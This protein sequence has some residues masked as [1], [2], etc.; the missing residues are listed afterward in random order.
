MRI[1]A[2]LLW[3]PLAARADRRRQVHVDAVHGSDANSGRSPAEALA[4]TGAAQRAVR[5]L[6]AS[7]PGGAGVDVLLQ[8]GV[9]EHAA[10]LELDERDG[11]LS[12]ACPAAMPCW[13]LVTLLTVRFIT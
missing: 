8:S 6:L 7:S 10:P 11:G 5:S 13:L 9:Y 4:T 2:L 12:A 1:P 3:L